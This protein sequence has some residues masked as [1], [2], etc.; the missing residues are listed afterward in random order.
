MTPRWEHDA[1]G[2]RGAGG[3]GGGFAALGASCRRVVGV[4]RLYWCNSPRLL[5]VRSRFGVAWRPKC[6]PP[7]RQTPTVG[8][9]GRGG[10]RCGHNGAWP[11]ASLA[12]KASHSLDFN[13][14][15]QETGGSSASG[16]GCPRSHERVNVRMSG[17]TLTLAGPGAAQRAHVRAGALT[18]GRRGR[19]RS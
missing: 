18:P 12:R 10:L 8:C 17:P 14:D 2:E 4:S 3:K 13:L 9:C 5:A 7:L 15:V 6:R 11:R 16:R 1:R 19:A